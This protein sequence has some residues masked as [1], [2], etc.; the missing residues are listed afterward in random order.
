MAPSNEPVMIMGMILEG[1]FA[2]ALPQEPAFVLRILQAGFDPRAVRSQ[3]PRDVFNRC[4]DIAG[5]HFY[6]SLSSASADWELGRR[7]YDGYMKTMAGKVAALTLPLMGPERLLR[8]YPTAIKMDP[9]P[10]VLTSVPLEPRRWRLEA[11][12]DPEMR[13]FFFASQFRELL[14]YTGAENPKVEV[15]ARPELGGF[16][17]LCTW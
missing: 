5:Q 16:D 1:M 17:L 11:R 15:L 10:M 14:R 7:F 3:Y 4:M 13:I 2:L 12:N 6:P 9:G 8:R